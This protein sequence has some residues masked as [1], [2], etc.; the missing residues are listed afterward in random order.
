VHADSPPGA[1]EVPA[2]TDVRALAASL[3][4][5]PVART[6]RLRLR[7]GAALGLRRH[8]RPVDA[9]GPA[10]GWDVVEL[11]YGSTDQLADEV[12]THGAD[13]VV[14]QPVELRETVVRRLRGAVE[15]AS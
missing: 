7:T 15:A 5:A 1:F 4:P 10:E 13:V 2:G 8:A 3:A 6:A 14:E 12:L 9:P 11:D